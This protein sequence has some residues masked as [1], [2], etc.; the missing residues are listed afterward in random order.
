MPVDEAQVENTENQEPTEDQVVEIP[1]E[2][3]NMYDFNKANMAQI[4]PLEVEAVIRLCI[5]AMKEIAIGSFWMLL[6]RETY[7]YTVFVNENNYNEEQRGLALYATLVNR[8]MRLSKY[9]T[10]LG[11]KVC[12]WFFVLHKECRRDNFGP[13]IK[14]KVLYM[15]SHY[16]KIALRNIR[17]YALQNTVSVIGLAAGFVCLCLSSAWL[18]YEKTF[19]RFIRMPTASIHTTSQHRTERICYCRGRLTSTLEE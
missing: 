13:T 18:Y 4:E 7:D 2:E 11:K 10:L 15:F 6:N 8:G 12:F 3:I 1:P 16:L 14:S 17:K 9:L 5:D 19:D